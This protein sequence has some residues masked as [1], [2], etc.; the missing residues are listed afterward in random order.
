LLGHELSG[1]E[2]IRE[3]PCGYFPTIRAPQRAHR[4]TGPQPFSDRTLRSPRNSIDA[5][6]RLLH[7]LLP[8]EAFFVD[9]NPHWLYRHSSGSRGSDGSGMNKSGSLVPLV[10]P[11]RQGIRHWCA[12]GEEE[13][14]LELRPFLS[15]WIEAEDKHWDA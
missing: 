4:A 6:E 1:S 9:S 2:G 5:T 3:G 7:L 14:S 13:C 8:R 15:A 11:Q 10:V 12:L